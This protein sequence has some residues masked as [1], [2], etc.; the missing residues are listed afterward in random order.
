[1]ARPIPGTGGPKARLA[2]LGAWRA[3]RLR[4]PLCGAGHI[5]RRWVTVV[6]TCPRC[7]LRLDRGEPDY[8]IGA[9]LFNLIAAE[10]L[11]ACAV[12]A[13]LLLTWPNPP[14]D[15]LYWGGIAGTI[16][17][18]IV[19]YPVTKLIWLTFDLLFRPPHPGDFTPAA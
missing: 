4:C 16:V 6:P 10:T 12:L 7:R 15:A 2:V 1:M 18:P 11:F 8:W 9:M 5:T 14:W 17:M 13:V 19:T 3:L